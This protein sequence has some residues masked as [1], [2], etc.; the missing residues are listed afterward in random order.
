MENLS[1][2]SKPMDQTVLHKDLSALN[3]KVKHIQELLDKLKA[4]S[5]FDILFFSSAL[6]T[7]PFECFCS[8]KQDAVRSRLGPHER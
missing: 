8:G 6:I 2:L 1:N 7:I 4:K 5:L 3:D